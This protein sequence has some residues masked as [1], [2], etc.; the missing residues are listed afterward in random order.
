V[1][2]YGAY[3]LFYLLI[4]HLQGSVP[5][6]A[7]LFASYGLFLAATQGVENALVADLAVDGERG[8]AFGWFNLVTGLA[9]LPASFVFGWLYETFSPKSAFTL[10]A[11]FALAA[12]GLIAV[13]PTPAAEKPPNH[14]IQ[15][16]TKS[17][18]LHLFVP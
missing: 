8:T 7:P 5:W 13:G 6:I 11:G 10:A 1:G 15:Y 14:R 16:S 17:Q 2:G 18:A 12:A 9:L 3:G 4:G